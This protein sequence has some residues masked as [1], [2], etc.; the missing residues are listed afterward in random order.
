VPM[1][2][3]WPIAVNTAAGG[4]SCNICACIVNMAS[5]AIFEAGST[6]GPFALQL[7]AC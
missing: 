3:M 2:S 5:V 4:C 7:P 1:V 6:V